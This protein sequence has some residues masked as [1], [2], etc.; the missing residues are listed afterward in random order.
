[1]ETAV[2]PAGG[3]VPIVEYDYPAILNIE[4]CG[5]GMGIFSCQLAL[6]R[7][8]AEASLSPAHWI[9]RYLVRQYG[10]D[11]FAVQNIGYGVVAQWI[12]ESSAVG[13]T[14]IADSI[15]AVLVKILNSGCRLSYLV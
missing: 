9:L 5:V 8:C 14:D 12:V 4:E 10:A 11:D 6:R 3:F 2:R 1:M 7:P 13:V 15:S